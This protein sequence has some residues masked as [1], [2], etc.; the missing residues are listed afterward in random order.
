MKEYCKPLPQPTPWSQPFWAGCREGRLLIQHCGD[1]D[2]YVFYPKLFCPF[3]LSKNL[4]WIESTGRGKIYSYTAVHS[5][6]PSEFTADVPYVIAII[7]L[8]EGVRLMSN[9]I[10]CQPEQV[11]CDMDVEV[12]FDKVTEEVTLPKFRPFAR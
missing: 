3:C 9:I 11:R 8:D 10:E 12:V 5:Y 2:Q 4:N 7:L 1:C 6:Q